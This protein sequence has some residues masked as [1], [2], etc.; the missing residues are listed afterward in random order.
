MGDVLIACDKFKGSAD[1]EQVMTTLV[2]GIPGARGF[3]VA[4]GGDGTLR[5]LK[6]AGLD[7]VPVRVTGPTGQAVDTEIVAGDGRVV[8]EMAD[9]CGMLRLP[10][11]ELAPLDA[12]SRGLGEAILAAHGHLGPEGDLIVGLG[13]SASNDGGCGVLVGL[14]ARLL[15][16]GGAELEPSAGVL[17]R[18]D[19]VD[20][21]GIPAWVREV[22]VTLASD[23]DAP[24]LG[25]RGA[26]RVFGPQKGLKGADADQV[27]A[28]MAHWADVLAAATGHD[29]RE[30]PGAGAAGGVGFA[31]MALMHT[32]ARSGI[33]VILEMT[34]FA[35]ALPGAD[36]VVTGEG[37]LD[38]QTLM[39]KTVAGVC[40]AAA[41]AGVPVE[42]VCGRTT[43]DDEEQAQLGIR[44]IHA[45]VDRAPD[46]ETAMSDA[47]RLLAEVAADIAAEL[48]ATDTTGT[49]ETTN[50]ESGA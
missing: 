42:A 37:S 7:A 19:T 16:S 22:D 1:A 44:R 20:L 2:D 15:D 17:G 45:L 50:G 39:G 40:R 28:D 29:P 33:E 5:A 34:G 49:T 30:T 3:V 26:V 31:L 4:D 25:E 23:V 14:G 9:A 32:T 48:D 41:A 47:L 27:E 43:L 35:D 36:L 13:G 11:G 24:L 21:S 10:D 8:V 38:Q 46:T 12:S 18:V 6:V